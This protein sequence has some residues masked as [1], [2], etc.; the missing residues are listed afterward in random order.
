MDDRTEFGGEPMRPRRRKRSKLQ[1]FKETYLPFVIA[2]AAGLL[3]LIIVIGSITRAVQRSNAR[4]EAQLQASIAAAQEQKRLEAEAATISDEATKLAASFDYD[5]AIS[6]IEGF[7]GDIDKF[8]QL[9]RLY[10]QYVQARSELV[11]WDD[12]SQI[13]NL[14]V[15]L[16]IAD[17]ER[18][19]ENEEY[20]AS[21]L[22]NF[23][24]V[25][26]FTQILQQLYENSYI[27][28]DMPQITDGAQTKALAL[29][30]G[31]KPLML[32][33]TQVN[34][35][36]YMVDGDGDKLPDKD[37]AGF[38][39]KLVLDANDNLTCEFVT[40]EGITETGAYDLV[41]ILE[42]FIATHPDF[43]YQGARAT[44]AIT[45]Y[46]GIFG[47]R[48]NASAKGRLGEEAYQKELEEAT[49]VVQALR[50]AGYKIA[51][52]TYD[53]TAYGSAGSSKIEADLDRWQKEISPVV[54]VVDTLVYA[55]NSDI[56]NAATAYEGTKFEIL[57]NFGF[58]YYLGFSTKGQPWFVSGVD[59]VRQGRIL[60]T[61]SNL[62]SHGAW[63]TDMFDAAAVL[64]QSREGYAS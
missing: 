20:G 27:L 41:P 23:I 62:T 24:T 60:L 1:V 5:G 37:G 11:V 64:D 44:L 33:Q 53:N 42:A 3:I 13:P 38:A 35:Y 12:P 52:S 43:S 48:I 7:S 32:T 39:S 19:F 45:G 30:A 56:A 18:A 50:N 31:K 36:T 16:L 63:F 55:R 21:F 58:S 2:A 59:H 6:T 34:Y 22:K 10:E 14:S 40:A 15:Q 4:E 9:Q 47:Y 8:A 54:G 49:K 57:Q 25:E 29:P 17:P 28:V 46:D 61:G 26:E 51:C